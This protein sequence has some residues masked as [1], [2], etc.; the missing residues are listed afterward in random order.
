MSEVPGTF[1]IN[2]K[3][4]TGTLDINTILREGKLYELGKE[5]HKQDTN[6]GAPRNRDD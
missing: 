2:K 6:I 1:P 3:T 5:L 4:F